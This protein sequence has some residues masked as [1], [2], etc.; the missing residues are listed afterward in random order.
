NFN[1]K[2]PLHPIFPQDLYA[3]IKKH[4]PSV[5]FVEGDAARFYEELLSKQ[6]EDPWWFVLYMTKK[7]IQGQ[8]PNVIITNG[9]PAMERAI[10]IEYPLARHLL[11]IWH[12][13][14]NLKKA[15]RRKLG[16]LFADFYSAFWKCQNTETPDAFNYY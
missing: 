4:K 11:C 12:I 2:Y 15:L 13:K 1:Q 10:I 9:D 3:E 14:E 6:C 16:N 7:A 8:T 5:R